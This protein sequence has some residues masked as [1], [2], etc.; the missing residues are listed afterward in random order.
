[1]LLEGAEVDGKKAKNGTEVKLDVAETDIVLKTNDNN[2]NLIKNDEKEE[3]E[4]D[5]W[6]APELVD[7][8]PAWAELNGKEK[9]QR[10]GY[11]LLRF[12]VILGSL[13][14]FICS[15]SL[16]SDAFR[17]LGGKAAGEA[18]DE[19]GIVANPI[20]GLMLGV[21]VTVLVQSS[22]TSTSIIVTMVG[23]DILTVQHAVPIIMGANIGTSVTNT[24]VSF[25]Q[26]PN[27]DEFRRAFGGAT[28]HDMFNWLSVI[29]LLPIEI[30]THYLYWLSHALT[31]NIKG[32]SSANQD[33]LKAL[34]SPFTNLIIQ[35]DKKVITNIALGKEE[36]LNKSLIK[37]SCG[38]TINIV[39]TNMSVIQNVTDPSTGAITLD[40]TYEIVN[41]SNI[42]KK[43][44][45]FLFANTGMSDPVVGIIL[46]FMSIVVLCGCLIMLVKC[47]QALLKGH[48]AKIIKRTINSD[49]PGR[50]SVLT[51][52][53]FML[54][55]AGVTIIVQSSSVF[56]STL[57]PLVGIGVIELERMYPLTLGSNIGTTTTGILAALASKV[58]LHNA[59]Q[60]A[61]CHLFFNISG[62][63][64]WYPIPFMRKIP[65]KMARFMGNTTAK[66]RW[67][68]VAYLIFAFFIIPG[69]I[70]GLSLAGW[71]VL[72]A[73]GGPVV[74]LLIAIL[75]INVLQQRRPKVLPKKLRTWEWAP[76]WLKSL[77]PY[78]KLLG[79]LCFCCK[80]RS[81]KPEPETNC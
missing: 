53:V 14:L 62:I 38:S 63:L 29:V 27:R 66:Y 76:I 73:V 8:S 37:A 52:Y 54:V 13:Y 59:M 55:G 58:G 44:C 17:L 57:T 67:F 30:I 61:I 48:V 79:R 74:L 81:G 28:V 50:W 49:F 64:V 65:V 46:L 41:I 21:L 35:L 33:L 68:A 78:D 11:L 32:D 39:P 70:L 51:G 56:T 26:S 16:L 71:Y 45:H 43:P 10:V 75:I 3:K 7:N 69:T 20:A 15:L 5:P 22:S 2:R 42:D 1:M 47:L 4:Y 9:L 31:G 80:Y 77:E 24:I 36:Y 60:I 25:A 19:E 40:T 12:V 34:T 72:L 6:Q 23:A 18:L